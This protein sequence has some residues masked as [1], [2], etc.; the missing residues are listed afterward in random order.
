MGNR[1]PVLSLEGFSSTIELLPREIGTFIHVASRGFEPRL[2]TPFTG[3][4]PANPSESANQ[5]T[6]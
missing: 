4:V 5:Y 6:S 3:D 1:T 2:P